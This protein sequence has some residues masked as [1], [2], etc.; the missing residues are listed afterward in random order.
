ML[1][2][3]LSSAMPPRSSFSNCPHNADLPAP[4][5]L[6]PTAVMPSLGPGLRDGD[7]IA[8]EV[9]SVRPADEYRRAGTVSAAIIVPQRGFNVLGHLHSWD[10]GRSFG[11]AVAT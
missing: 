3:G 5:T 2:G 8:Q 4:G 10:C 7:G 1:T 6:G 9:E 11:T